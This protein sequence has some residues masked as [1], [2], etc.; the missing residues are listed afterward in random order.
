MSSQPKQR[1][2]VDIESATID[3]ILDPG[4]GT[5]VVLLP[6]SLRDSE[7]FDELARLIALHGHG[8]IRPQPRGM[9]ASSPPP[10]GMTLATLAGDVA[11]VLGKLGAGPAIVVGHAYGHWVAR[12]LDHLYPE[13]VVGVVVLAAA[14][15]EFP[16]GTAERLAVASDTTRTPSERLAALQ[17]CM[18]A[19]GND[20]SVWLSGWYP[21]WRDAYRQASVWPPKDKWYGTTH[22]PLLDVQG[23]QDVWR[24]PHTRQALPDLLG[25]MASVVLVPHAGHA[26]VPEQPEAVAQA[27]LN[28]VQAQGLNQHPS[29]L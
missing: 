14:A 21:Q 19:P 6:S 1:L 5:P 8:V 2:L 3:V 23:E 25:P 20:A 27:I 26:M 12:V 22:A 11:A 18:F 13:K 29:R 16:A 28:W 7:D 15:R 24:P 17:A 9:G 4:P 10:D